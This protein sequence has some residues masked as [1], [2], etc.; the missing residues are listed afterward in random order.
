M[1]L[2]LYT[3]PMSRGRITRWMLEECG[4]SYEAVQLDYGTTMKAP[5]Y[6]A[7]N[8]MGKVPALTNGDAVV[9]EVAAICLWLADRFPDKQ[10][11]PALNTPERAA[12]YRWIAFISGP[13]EAV[14]TAK[15]EGHFAKPMQAGYGTLADVVRT[16]EGA[17]SRGPYL[18]GDHF[19]AADLLMSAYL[20]FYTQWKLLDANPVFARYYEPHLA[21][22]AQGRANAMDEAL[23]AQQQQQQQ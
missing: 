19:T 21:R 13:F 6:L 9:T 1:S 7:I 22:P 14:M 20:S 12:Y 4:A 8:P 18:C 11:A 23:M 15:A 5:N 16:L 2:T 3:N 10:L 17:V